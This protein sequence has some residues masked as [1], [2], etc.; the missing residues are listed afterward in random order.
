M[1]VLVKEQYNNGLAQRLDIIR[2]KAQ[3]VYDVDQ[4]QEAIAVLWTSLIALA[5]AQGHMQAML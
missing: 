5:K 1:Y 4:Y 3:A 2:A